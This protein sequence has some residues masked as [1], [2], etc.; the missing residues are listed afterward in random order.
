ME[1]EIRTFEDLI[2]F[3]ETFDLPF[4]KYLKIVQAYVR[5]G[6]VW[7]GTESKQ[8]LISE[9]N[10]FR[11]SIEIDCVPIFWNDTNHF[12]TNEFQKTLKEN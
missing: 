11:S 9:L 3:I 6:F 2:D 8:N 5:Q 7:V 1:I 4:D 10:R 12:K